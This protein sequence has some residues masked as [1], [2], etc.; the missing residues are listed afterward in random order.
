MHRN[1]A[2][3]EVFGFVIKSSLSF[4]SFLILNSLKSS[5]VSLIRN[6][7]NENEKL[8][9]IYFY[10]KHK[11]VTHFQQ[12][13]GFWRRYNKV[14]LDKLALDA[15]KRSL[16]KENQTLRNVLCQYLDGVSVNNE[17]LKEPNPLFV[18]NQRTNVKLG[19]NIMDPRVQKPNATVVEAAHIVNHTLP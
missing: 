6:S 3:S 5:P 19:V 7:F 8:F 2:K 11:V 4:R 18:V 13:D 12:L 17:T 1:K 9:F 16:E 14:Q 10:F 15:E